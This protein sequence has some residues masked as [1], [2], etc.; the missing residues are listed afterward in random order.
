[1][2]SCI[3]SKKKLFLV[4]LLLM[5]LLQA[6]VVVLQRREVYISG[7]DF[8]SNSVA[9]WY[10]SQK[11]TIG[12][13]ILNFLRAFIQAKG[14]RVALNRTELTQNNEQTFDS[15]EDN[16]RVKVKMKS[17]KDIEKSNSNIFFI[18][19]R[20][21]TRKSLQML[22]LNS[23]FNL[24]PRQCCSVESA[25][26]MNPTRNVYIL[27]TCPLGRDFDLHLPTYARNLLSLDNVFVVRLS[28]GEALDGTPVTSLYRSDKLENSL[29]PVVHAS[30]ILRLVVLWRFGGTYCDMDILFIRLF[31]M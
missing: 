15:S 16:N 4:V 19:S 22:D 17:F 9:G 12:G 2:S 27:H 30:D 25:A 6:V 1:M 3:Y 21:G 29:Y 13:R 5:L 31:K 26:T 14:D 11:N 20:C 23:N 24:R 18:E 7:E 10:S 8:S 28:M